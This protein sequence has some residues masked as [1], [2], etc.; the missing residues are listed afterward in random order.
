[1]IDLLFF[2]FVYLQTQKKNT[3]IINTK[4]NDESRHC[5]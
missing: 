2:K 1:M 4:E 5:S 3:K